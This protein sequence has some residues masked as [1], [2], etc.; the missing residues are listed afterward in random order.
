MLDEASDDAGEG[1]RGAPRARPRHPPGG[2]Q[3]P[4]PG[5]RGRIARPALAP[6]GRDRRLRRRAAPR[7]GRGRRPTSSSPRRSPM[8]SVTLAPDRAEVGI[9]RDNGAPRGRGPR[10]TASAAR[11]RRGSGL[12]GLADRVAALDGRLRVDDPAGGGTIVRADIPLGGDGAADAGRRRRGLGAAARGRGAAAAGG[13]ARGGGPGRRRGRP[14]AQG[15]G[16]QARPRRRRRAHAADPDRRGAPRAAKEIRAEL[17]GVGVLVLSGY[18]EPTYAQEL[19]AENAEGLGYLLKDRV[20]DVD[21]VRRRGRARRDRRVGARP[22]GRLGADGSRPRGRP[23][24]GAHPARAGGARP[25]GGG[26]L[27]RRD[28][29]AARGHRACRREARH[30]DLQQ[31]RPHGQQRGSPRVLAVLRFLET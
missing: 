12:R 20:S 28:R 21:R 30:L 24:G 31:A 3:R 6:P 19:L 11:T 18:V 1:H 29:R 27:Q 14:D 8:S 23:A 2:P 16:A 7:A 25:D 22:G 4:R 10:T 26:P 15:A 13:R 17:P 5:G 9:R